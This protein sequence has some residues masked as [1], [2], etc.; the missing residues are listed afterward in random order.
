MSFRYFVD[1]AGV[2]WMVYSIS[3]WSEER[4]RQ[5]RRRSDAEGG[6]QDAAEL[7]RRVSLLRRSWMPALV[8]DGWLSFESEAEHR[9]LSP[10]PEGWESMTVAALEALRD[11]ASVVP[12]KVRPV[13]PDDARLPVA[14]MPARDQQG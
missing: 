14:G 2:D 13:V 10:I 4:R 8:R 3:P 5:E 6:E 1:S 11:Q 9:R 7:D 12:R